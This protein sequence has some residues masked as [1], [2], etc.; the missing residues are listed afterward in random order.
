MR[1]NDECSVKYPK[2]ERE[3]KLKDH[4]NASM[5]SLLD[6]VKKAV[7]L[8]RM[9]SYGSPQTNYERIA[10]LWNAYLIGQDESALMMTADDVVLMMILVKVAR[11]SES[12]DHF[13][14]WKDISGYGAVGWVVSTSEEMMNALD[15]EIEEDKGE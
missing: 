14:S 12:P 13:D 2:I 6:E 10:T 7:T 3:K 1:W 5:G 9:E 15:E 8:D 11:L 4:A